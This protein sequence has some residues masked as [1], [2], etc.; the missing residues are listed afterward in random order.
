MPNLLTQFSTKAH[1]LGCMITKVQKGSKQQA[2]NKTDF[3]CGSIFNIL[4]VERGKTCG[5]SWDFSV[6]DIRWI[7]S[8]S[9][10]L[11]R[12]RG[13]SKKDCNPT[14]TK[15]EVISNFHI[16]RTDRMSKRVLGQLKP[17]GGLL[18][19]NQVS[20]SDNPQPQVY[21][22]VTDIPK[23]CS[24]TESALHVSCE[25]LGG[26]EDVMY[27]LWASVLWPGSVSYKLCL[28]EFPWKLPIL[29][30]SHCDQNSSAFICFIY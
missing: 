12:W 11:C 6:P 27:P 10:I 29:G 16:C 19:K 30:I 20:F 5:S 21:K 17:V 7:M 14:H 15:D 22:E 25:M 3:S 28:S 1:L 8:E 24:N 23:L 9:G 4:K 2:S 26:L 18:G 13:I